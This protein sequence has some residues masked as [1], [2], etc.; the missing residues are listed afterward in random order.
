[1]TSFIKRLALL[2]FVGAIAIG[3]IGGCDDESTDADG[4]E[5]ADV[6]AGSA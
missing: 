6:D 2:T 5:D 4:T 1:M 3:A